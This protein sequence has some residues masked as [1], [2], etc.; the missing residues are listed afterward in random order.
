MA[1]ILTNNDFLYRI[2]ETIS[3]ANMNLEDSI[4]A[5]NKEYN[6]QTDTSVK[7]S[8]D[9]E[10]VFSRVSRIIRITSRLLE[11]CEEELLTISRIE[12]ITDEQHR[13]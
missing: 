10:E 7:A 13:C 6:G 11:S 9:L 2:A 5:L 12:A 3:D 8:C 4:G 1:T